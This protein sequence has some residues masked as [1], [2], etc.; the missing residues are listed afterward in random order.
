[1]C[2]RPSDNEAGFKLTSVVPGY[3]AGLTFLIEVFLSERD[4]L[5]NF[6]TVSIST[7]GV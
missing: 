4:R 1:M 6:G 3:P 2:F 7:Q 5:V